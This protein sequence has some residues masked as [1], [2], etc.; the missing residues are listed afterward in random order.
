MEKLKKEW[1][2]KWFD[3]EEVKPRC[4]SSEEVHV[5]G[6]PNAGRV[7][8]GSVW[9]EKNGDIQEFFFSR[10]KTITQEHINTKGKVRNCS[11]SA[12]GLN[13]CII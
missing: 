8:A 13:M 2:A 12:G 9:A 4:E 5:M 1:K 6:Y 3:L 7:D 11:Q 10:K